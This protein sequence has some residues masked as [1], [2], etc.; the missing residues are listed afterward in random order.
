MWEFGDGS[1]S[2][3]QYPN[4]AYS[5]EGV[6]TV[7]LTVT[8]DTG[9]YDW[10]LTTATIGEEDYSEAG[11]YTIIVEEPQTF[12]LISLQNVKEEL[13]LQEITAGEYTQIRLTIEKANITINNSGN[14]EM[15]DLIVPSGKVKLIKTFWIYED[16]T[17]VLTLDFDVYESVHQTGNDKFILK[18]T[19]KVIQE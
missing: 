5:A 11:W 6:Y 15:F 19:I 9:V 7:N 12:D 13:G 14:I 1:I 2:N 3:D 18:P 17:T 4:Y 10:Y 16:D 8:N